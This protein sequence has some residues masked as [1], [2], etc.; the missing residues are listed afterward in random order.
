MRRAPTPPTLDDR[1]IRIW[2]SRRD[3]PT[4]TDGG[5]GLALGISAF[6]TTC[7]QPHTTSES[8]SGGGDNPAVGRGDAAIICP[9][10]GVRLVSRTYTVRNV[11]D[12]DRAKYARWAAAAESRGDPDE[13]RSYRQSLT[14]WEKDQG[15]KRE[16]HVCA[17]CGDPWLVPTAAGTARRHRRHDGEAVTWDRVHQIRKDIAALQEELGRVLDRLEP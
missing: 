16:A 15:Q 14:E 1:L 11:S 5:T 9:G 17:V 12:A 3:W 10:S 8:T 7:H 6:M 2:R 13:A 4:P